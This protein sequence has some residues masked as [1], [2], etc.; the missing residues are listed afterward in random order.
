MSDSVTGNV[1]HIRKTSKKLA[2]FDIE[3]PPSDVRK[4]VVLKSWETL[5]ILSRAVKGKEKIHLGDEVNYTGYWETDSVFCALNYDLVKLWSEKE[6]GTSFVPRPPPQKNVPSEEKLLCKQFLNT[7]KCSVAH[8]DFTHLE[9][10]QLLVEKRQQFVQQ[11]K[12]RQILEHENSFNAEV[13]SNSQ[14]ARI[15]SEWI[16]EEFGLEHLRT[17]KVLD[18]AGGRGDLSFEL[19]KS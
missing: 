7:G 6:P 19:R 13:V 16:V 4:T 11:K 8:C 12:E 17:G 18:I 5:E 2:F 9:D 3:V 14:R 15:F 10:R 1:V